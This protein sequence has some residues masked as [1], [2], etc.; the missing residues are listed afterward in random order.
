LNI[1]HTTGATLNAISM[2]TVPPTAGVSTRR[3]APIFQVKRN[4]ASEAAQTSK[5]ISGSPPAPMALT[6]TDTKATLC[7]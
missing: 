4:V 2:S 5:A 7:A 1:F 3:K 6:L